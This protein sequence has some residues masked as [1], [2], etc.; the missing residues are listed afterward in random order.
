MLCSR[1]LALMICFAIAGIAVK[2][3]DVLAQNAILV[4]K[5]TAEAVEKV[6]TRPGTDKIASYVLT[7]GRSLA[8]AIRQPLT[9]ST[10]NALK[11]RGLMTDPDR[12][13]CTACHSVDDIRKKA[14][15]ADTTSVTRFGLQGTIGP[16]LDG[17]A[18]RYTEGELRLLVVNPQ[19]ALPGADSIM[20]AYHHVEGRNRVKSGC[21]GRVLLTA[22]EVE[23]IV[24]YLVTLKTKAK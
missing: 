14:R 3:F 12:G 11:G 8:R 13:N 16:V 22:E 10:G 21:E 4:T 9:G 5:K 15:T 17:I 24:A 20:P 2:P 1:I 7:K 18:I 6:C 23:D 19:L